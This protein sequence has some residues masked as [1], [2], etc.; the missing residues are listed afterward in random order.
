MLAIFR[1]GY[2][3]AP[4]RPQHHR[5][6][7]KHDRAAPGGGAS[8]S[9]AIRGTTIADPCRCWSPPLRPT[10]RT[11][12]GRI[13]RADHMAI[14]KP[15]ASRPRSRSRR[16]SAPARD[17]RSRPTGPSTAE[18]NVPALAGQFAQYA[19][20]S[21]LGA[22]AHLTAAR[23]QERFF[24]SQVTE[25]GPIWPHGTPGP[26]RSSSSPN[27]RP[28]IKCRQFRDSND[29]RSWTRTRDL[30]LIRKTWCPLQSPQ[31]AINPCKTMKHRLRKATGEDWSL[32][33]GGPIVA[34]RPQFE[35][36][37][38]YDPEADITPTIRS[39][40]DAVE[41]CRCEAA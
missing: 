31:I 36:T 23:N 19:A 15:S 14:V 30:F 16:R 17:G 6:A 41:A 38:S 37:V 18:A 26:C 4:G 2:N 29:G 24:A 32:Q 33:A 25:G 28:L 35:G 11:S 5:V 9:T 34:P 21:V 3:G 10:L 40:P 39:D 22:R 12:M 1:H 13:A 20:D 7:A 27:P 8:A